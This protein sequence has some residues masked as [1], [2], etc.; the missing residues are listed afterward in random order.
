MV[1][2]AE[3]R[4]RRALRRSEVFFPYFSMRVRYEDRRT[5][6]ALEPAGIRVTPVER[7]YRRLIDFALRAQWGRRPISRAEAIG[8]L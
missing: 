3:D 7:Y 2:W 5:R 4:R 1:R 8:A 6:A